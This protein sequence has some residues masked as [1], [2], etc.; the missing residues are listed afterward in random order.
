MASSITKA[1]STIG[2]TM[3]S[4]SLSPSSTPSI[5]PL[6]QSCTGAGVP[7]LA[8]MTQPYC[9]LPL[10]G[11]DSSNV[12]AAMRACCNG[13]D[14]IIPQ[15]GCHVYCKA[16]GQTTEQLIRCL[17]SHFSYQ[18]GNTQGI[19]CDSAAALRQQ[20]VS[21]G[22]MLVTGLLGLSLFTGFLF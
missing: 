2:T 5:I 21:L 13:A 16:V 14:F 1:S 12:S 10:Q 6:I 7:T 22:S 9:G 17:G 3:S 15:D 4:S 11:A 20:G 8:N 18:D 19:G